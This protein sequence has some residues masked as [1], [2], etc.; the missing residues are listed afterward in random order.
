MSLNDVLNFYASGVQDSP[1][2]DP[3]LKVNG[4]PGIPLN[5]D[6]KTKIIEFLKTLSDEQFLSDPR[7]SQN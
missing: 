3:A 1:T 7:F 5:N 6:E 2:L 4:T